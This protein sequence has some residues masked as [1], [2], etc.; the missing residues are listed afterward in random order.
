MG[1]VSAFG[2]TVVDLFAGIGYYT[3]QLLRHAGVAKVYACEWNP[4]SV[5]ALRA[6][7]VSNGGVVQ[8]QCK[9]NAIAIALQCTLN[10]VRPMS[11]KAV[12]FQTVNHV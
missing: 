3:L 10:S 5:A 6:N 2:E 9:C 11:L 4:N 7:L 8:M 12:R 1:H